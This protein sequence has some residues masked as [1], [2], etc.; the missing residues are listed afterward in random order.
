MYLL[1]F[2]SGNVLKYVIDASWFHFGKVERSKNVACK[3]WQREREIC[4][5][6]FWI[7]CILD[8]EELEIATI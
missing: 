6:G 1:G 3:H 2:V 4:S 5:P 7:G 8:N